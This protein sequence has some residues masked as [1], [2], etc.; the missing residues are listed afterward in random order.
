MGI[1]RIEKAFEAG[2]KERWCV[3]CPVCGEFQ[4]YDWERIV[5]KDL[6]EP[7]MKCRKCDALRSEKSWK[8]SQFKGA[9]ISEKAGDVRTRSFH[10]NAF[11]SPWTTWTSL[12]EQYEEAYRNGEEEL[13]V[14][15][16]TKLGLPWE[17]QSGAIEA[18]ILESRREKYA[19]SVPDGVLV[20]TCG[21]DTQDDRLE[22]EVVGWGVG[23]ESW[24]IEYRFLYGDPGQKEVWSALDD[25][26]THFWGYDDGEEI[27]ISCACIDSAGHYT[28]DVYRFCKPRA[29]RNVF[30]IVGRGDSGK[31]SVSKPSRNNRR[32]V[33][34]FTLGVSTIKGSLFSRLKVERPGPG[35]CHFPLEPRTNHRGYDAPYFKG[36]VSERMVVK[37]VRGKERI[38]WEPRSAGIRNEPLDV[39]VY[40]TGALEIF[41]PDLEKRKERRTVKNKKKGARIQPSAPAEPAAGAKKEEKNPHPEPAPPPPPPPP[42]KDMKKAPTRKRGFQI[43]G[44][45]VR[46]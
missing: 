9:W 36:L 45:G 29:R 30:A 2:T 20:L 16:N 14:W 46:V 15:W 21:V 12:V 31:P 38:E 3:P 42:K 25:F 11:A 39:R 27:G 40:A 34:L 13:K 35:Y 10:L 8:S 43:L 41:N 26:L 1:S 4:P 5:Y 17:S 18:E 24:G 44:R 19:A 37:R 32:H 6:T 22:A 33:P 28:D 7:L 23:R